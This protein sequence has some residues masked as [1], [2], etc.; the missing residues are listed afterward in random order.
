MS[1]MEELTFFMGLQIK[2]SKDGITICQAKYNRELVRKYRM[3]EAKL[4]KTP[5]SMSIKLD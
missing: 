4:R 2:Q 3:S 1:M 5:T